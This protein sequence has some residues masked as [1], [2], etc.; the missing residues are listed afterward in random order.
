MAVQIRFP[1]APPYWSAFAQR[2]FRNINRVMSRR[3]GG[4][5]VRLAA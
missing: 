2:P 3:L 1:V 5:V 4:R